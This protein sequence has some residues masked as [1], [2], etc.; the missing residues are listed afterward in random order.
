MGKKQI[1]VFSCEYEDFYLLLSAK[2]TKTKASVKKKMK[3]NS[4]I[5]ERFFFSCVCYNV[6]TLQVQ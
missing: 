2:I 3:K 1:P 6:N 5:Y 4:Q